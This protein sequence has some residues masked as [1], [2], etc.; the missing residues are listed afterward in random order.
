[1]PFRVVI[2]PSAVRELEAIQPRPVL[3]RVVA[4]ARALAEA[5]RPVGA[6]KL[7]GQKQLYR[8]RV[9]RHR[10]VYQVDEE[11]RTVRIVKIG[12]RRDVY[13]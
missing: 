12:H 5:P 11:A 2:K 7:S 1:M 3:E 4:A 9:G 6:E 13:R 8:V 10:I